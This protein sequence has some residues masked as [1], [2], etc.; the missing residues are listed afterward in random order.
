MDMLRKTDSSQEATAMQIAA[1][2]KMGLS[3][4]AAM[5]F[6]L[7][8]NLREL[9][10]AGICRRHPNYTPQQVMQCVLSL[11]L[12]KT[13]FEQIFPGCEIEP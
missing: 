5:V 6:E 3:G 2:Q 1:L 11:V 9:V 7:S 12:D 10:T 4:R 8:D 13:V